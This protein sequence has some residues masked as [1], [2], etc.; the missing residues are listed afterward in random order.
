MGET[1][2]CLFKSN[3][4]HTIEFPFYVEHWMFLK[5]TQQKS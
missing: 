5:M 1:Q 3:S 2:D 4:D